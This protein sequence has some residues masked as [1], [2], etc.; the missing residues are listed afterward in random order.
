MSA[1][2]AET[3]GWQEKA[4]EREGGGERE[5]DE[6]MNKIT[7]LSIVHH[8]RISQYTIYI[9]LG[10]SVYYS[11]L[12]PSR[13]LHTTLLCSIIP[14]TISCRSCGALAFSSIL[15]S[16][17]STE[18]VGKEERGEG[19]RRNSRITIMADAGLPW[20]TYISTM[21]AG[22]CVMIYPQDVSSLIPRPHSVGLG[23]RPLNSRFLSQKKSF[24]IF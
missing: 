2:L 19:R 17:A 16:P 5:V 8:V 11:L 3:G 13:P 10:Y 15:H 20:L 4:W 7:I 9:M 12:H 22:T 21:A 6:R 18:V 23:M 14:S 24:M 1:G